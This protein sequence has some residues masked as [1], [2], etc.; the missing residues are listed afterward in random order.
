MVFVI[1]LFCLTAD[2]RRGRLQLCFVTLH[3]RSKILFFT[4]Y[5]FVLRSRIDVDDPNVLIGEIQFLA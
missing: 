2:G 4:G 3:I 1:H 5:I